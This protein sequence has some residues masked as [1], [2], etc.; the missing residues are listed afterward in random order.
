MAARRRL[1]PPMCAYG[2]TRAA[3]LPP[4]IR[5][6]TALH[7]A[8]VVLRPAPRRTVAAP[9]KCTSR[10]R[11][12]H[13]SR[14]NGVPLFPDERNMGKSPHRRSPRRRSRTPQR[15]SPA[16]TRSKRY[17]PRSTHKSPRKSPRNRRKSTS[18]RRRGNTRMLGL[19]TAANALTGANRKLQSASS[20]VKDAYNVATTRGAMAIGALAGNTD[21]VQAGMKNL[22]TLNSRLVLD[23][24]VFYDSD[25]GSSLSSS[26]ADKDVFYDSEDGSQRTT[27]RRS[28]IEKDARQY[29]EANPYISVSNSG[30]TS[31]V[32][33]L[34]LSDPAAI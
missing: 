24:D 7:G 22:E 16:R 2:R 9:R 23:G 15:R 20:A 10:A 1:F 32:P 28:S 30:I 4:R 17:T 18:P 3:R 31:Y 14:T 6:K 13:Q 25:N 12:P 34:R 33:P 8:A 26:K 5:T 11:L 21:V 27:T 29:V 19:E